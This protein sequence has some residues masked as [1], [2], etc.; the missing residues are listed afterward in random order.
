LQEFNIKPS[1]NINQ[2]FTESF[3]ESKIN[4]CLSLITSVK[5]LDAKLTNKRKPLKP[6]AQPQGQTQ[7]QTQPQKEE[8]DCKQFFPPIF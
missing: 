1:L 3:L 5:Q 8:I 6:K 4:F 7:A 2:F